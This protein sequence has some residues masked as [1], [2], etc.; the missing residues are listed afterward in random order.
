MTKKSTLKCFFLLCICCLQFKITNGQIFCPPQDPN[1]IPP[2]IDTTLISGN[3]LNLVTNFLAIGN[4]SQDDTTVYLNNRAFKEAANWIK[5][6]TGAFTLLLPSGTYY[7]GSQCGNPKS[8]DNY[9]KFFMPRNVF[10]LSDKDSVTITSA[11][12]AKDVELIFIPGLKYGGFI[13]PNSNDTTL[14]SAPDYD[15]CRSD[16]GDM[17]SFNNCNHIEI[18]NLYCNGNK[19]NQ[20]IGGCSGDNNSIQ[21]EHTGLNINAGKD[22]K[23]QN[24]SFSQFCLDGIRISGVVNGITNNYVLKKIICDSNGRQALSWVA[25]SGLTVDSSHLAF[26]GY[27]SS[28]NPIKHRERHFNPGTN[29]DLEPTGAL[30]EYGVF[31]TDTF[32]DSRSHNIVNWADNVSSSLLF[33][34]CFIDKYRCNL[35]YNIIIS[36][37]KV[38]FSNCRI[39]GTI[40]NGC[41]D[42]ILGNET[43]FD[44]C[45]ISDYLEY[46]SM[47][48]S[49][50]ACHKYHYLY[51]SDNGSKGTTFSN[52]VFNVVH[53]FN[54]A[55]LFRQPD[56]N[57]DHYLKLKD[58]KI[59]Y[60]NAFQSIYVPSDTYYREH[61]AG[62][63]FEG[64]DSII[65]QADT[66]GKYRLFEISRASVDADT[67]AC[68]TQGLY[69]KGQVAFWLYN[70]LKVGMNNTLAGSAAV[71]VDSGSLLYIL[72]STDTSNTE[73][74]NGSIIHVMSN[75]S[76]ALND[77][78]KAK[79]NIICDSN[80][81]LSVFGS[82]FFYNPF[83]NNSRLFIH[84]NTRFGIN[85]IY[86]GL[87]GSSVVY[88][89]TNQATHFNNGFANSVLSGNYPPCV[90][91]SNASIN[92]S[93]QCNI[94]YTNIS[95]STSFSIAYSLVNAICNG[96]A[97]GQFNYSVLGGTPPYTSSISNLSALTAGQYTVTFTDS[98]ACTASVN[99]TITQPLA[100]SW[101]SASF[102]NVSC[103]N[104]ADG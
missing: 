70:G 60:V 29:L 27:L 13:G 42:S 32:K 54:H 57:P 15:S 85:D 28:T 61:M 16:I 104:Q 33:K 39:K 22:Y 64:R 1:W 21:R 48:M 100:V 93:Y 2:V 31:T 86:S 53:P 47:A 46:D 9:G 83:S 77:T 97:T 94:P 34:N 6:H 84:Q 26:T 51:Y 55:I 79:G 36:C 99:F 4:G 76:L 78:L 81:Y 41:N 50:T 44:S 66:L 68:S 92:S 14:D 3:T 91:G 38:K 18:S 52:T 63:K 69:L 95:N 23:I 82:S 75:G 65:T 59:N 90:I 80:S 87:F 30:L 102:V 103:H 43:I 72:N 58:S 20:L 96:S 8:L 89:G 19:E 37:K 7:I 73:L 25:G 62:I 88:S 5:N 56:N 71:S 98:N 24:C 17:F 45:I 40:L 74:S 12:G 49:D 11:S 10:V 67:F 101:V 35:D